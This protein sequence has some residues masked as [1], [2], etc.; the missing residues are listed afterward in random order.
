MLLVDFPLILKNASLLLS[1][2]YVLI[3]HSQFGIKDAYLFYSSLAVFHE[4]SPPILYLLNRC[5]PCPA[6]CPLPPLLSVHIY[7]SD[8]CVKRCWK[9][10]RTNC[11]LMY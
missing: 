2:P 4:M 9:P 11:C 1:M 10:S 8:L 3:V 5:L 6:M 7:M